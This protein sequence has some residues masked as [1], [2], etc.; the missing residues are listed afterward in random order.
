MGA[1]R[2]FESEM[3][4]ERSADRLR[5]AAAVLVSAGAIWNL[6]LARN[7]A[8]IAVA[9]LA[10]VAAIAW[11]RRW[12][13]YERA[14]PP[15]ARTRLELSP[16]GLVLTPPVGAPRS[17]AWADV[18]GVEVDQDYLV[19]RVILEGAEPLVIEPV[20]DG[21]AIDELGDAIHVAHVAGLAARSG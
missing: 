6:V 1:F 4:G 20:F 8:T 21:V 3:R 15:G 9:A 13:R 18:R 12:A 16:E 11:A 7:P 17:V 5:L 10:L 14:R 2:T 19:V